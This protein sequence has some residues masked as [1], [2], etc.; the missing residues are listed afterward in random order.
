MEEPY[1]VDECL[2]QMMQAGKFD[3]TAG[4]ALGVFRIV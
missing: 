3:E 1:R 2:T 4:I